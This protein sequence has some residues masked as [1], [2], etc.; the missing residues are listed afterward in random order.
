MSLYKR[1]ALL[2]APMAL[3]SMISF[4]VG[5]A[6]NLMVG[7]LG[8][9]ALS[10]VY[11]ANQIQN[12]LHMLVA[13]LEASMIV[14][15]T[16]YW[17]RK[18]A[19]NT[20]AIIGISLKFSIV[21]SS[22]LLL[23]TLAY[24]E[25]ILRL[26]SNEEAVIAE[27]LKYLSIIRYT[28]VFFCVNQVMIAAM[29]CV[30]QVRIG[31]FLSIFTFVVNVSLNWILI[32]GKLGAP[33]L[34]IEGAALATLIARILETPV[35]L[36]YI[37]FVDKK[38]QIRL[39]DLLVSK[40]L[41]VRDFFKYGFPIILGDILWG[42]NLMIQG[43]I[44]GRLGAVALA[45]TSI[46]NAVFSMMA[47]GVYGTAGASAII[48]GQTVGAK[49]YDKLR[50]YVRQLQI[51]FLVVGVFSGL[52]IYFAKDYILMLYNLTDETIVMAKQFLTILSVTIVGTSYQMS[53]LTGI[54][55]P[56]GST[57]FVLI[58]DSVFVWFVVIPS[59]LLAAFVFEAHPAVVFACLKCDQ[60]LKCAVAVVTV[61]RFN[62]V[63]NLTHGTD[64]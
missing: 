20:K 52:L 55:R 12:M 19:E 45:S 11:I 63:K 39:R 22:L 3:Q 4:S 25:Q 27:G 64:L 37:R 38:L 18:D 1:I 44:M 33:A 26:F 13:G 36:I 8:E 16:Q 60:I 35:I 17:G 61:N 58:N 56:G 24:P 53:C 49:E 31:L 30:E 59:A 21:A 47:V 50:L 6:D 54:V 29:R 15:A 62:W 5:L 2:A 40:A 42:I 48:I 10:G 7:S 41:L 32:F 46:A 14:L 23:A 28:Y 51:V 9:L 34:G 57:R 43:A